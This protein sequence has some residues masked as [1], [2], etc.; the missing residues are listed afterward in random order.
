MRRVELDTIP[1]P[2]SRE[3]PYI[4]PDDSTVARSEK[5]D[6]RYVCG[7]CGTVL[8][9]L[10]YQTTLG[11]VL[12]KLD[13]LQDLDR[14][15]NVVKCTNCGDFNEFPHEGNNPKS[16]EMRNSFESNLENLLQQV[17]E[18]NREFQPEGHY[19]DP[20]VHILNSYDEIYELD[21]QDLLRLP[22]YLSDAVL[23]LSPPRVTQDHFLYWGWTAAYLTEHPE[24][25]QFGKLSREFL[26]LIHMM[27][28]KIRHINSRIFYPRAGITTPIDGEEIS[29]EDAWKA[30]EWGNPS[31]RHLT[32]LPDRYAT[33][34]GFAVLE[35]L[36]CNHSDHLTAQ[37]KLSHDVKCPWRPTDQNFLHQGTSITYH[38]RLQVWRNY[39]A[40]NETANTLE[41]INDLTRYDTCIL[42]SNMEGIDNILQDE[43]E[44]TQNL[45]RVV[46]DQ[47]N[48]NLH[49]Q[50]H[51]RVFG[52]LVTTLC[53]LVIWD[54]L[55]PDEF[56]DHKERVI[57]KIYDEPDKAFDDVMS[58]PAFMPVDRVQAFLDV[59]FIT[60]KDPRYPEKYREFKYE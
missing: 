26:S 11:T 15:I 27:L 51:S 31:L 16:K 44:S 19:V 21:Y 14:E 5:A 39:D 42:S 43:A 29:W 59:D 37:G 30:I 20:D 36:I 17:S 38:D 54:A 24:K 12:S 1:E 18:S 45:L 35:G 60:P 52:T 23:R 6:V 48:S 40:Q 7:T 46:A 56:E 2:D 47:R 32:V 58:A 8:A 55:P 34:T 28:F 25:D 57:K 22:R 49:G 13:E 10:P 33:T 3:K 4:T 41:R 9:E 53:A 50:L